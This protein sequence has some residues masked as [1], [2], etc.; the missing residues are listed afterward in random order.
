MSFF[1]FAAG[2]IGKLAI[3]LAGRSLGETIKDIRTQR[4]MER[5]VADAVDRVVEQIDGYLTGEKVSDQRK[6]VLIASLCAN[7]Q[8]LTDDPQRF[9]AGNLDGALIFKQCHPD[10]KLP[11]EI[12]E[13]DLGH[14]YTM[15][16]PQIAHFLAGSRIALAQWQA[17]GYREEF[18]RLTQIAEEIRA[19]NVKVAELPGAVTRAVA[20]KADQEAQTLLREFAQ[21][22]LNNLLLRLDLSPLRAER[23]LHGSLREHFVIPAFR[24]RREHAEAVGKETVIIE[25][26]AAAGARRLVHGGAGVGKTT[27]SLWLQSRLLESDPTRLAVLLR[28]REITD[29][30]K[31][32]LL[33]LLRER[34]GTHLRDALTD[35][36]LR[37]WHRDGRLVVILDGFDEVPEDRRDAVEQWVKGLDAAAKKTTI[38]VTS[39][40]LQ[41]GHL[42]GLKRPWQ[43]WDLL[44]FDEPRIVEFIE[45]WH[46]YLPEGELSAAER[47]VDPRALA[48]TFFNDPSLKPL[49][50]TPLMLGTLLFVHHRDKKLPS[51]RVDLYERY[52]AAMLG[53]RDSGLGIQA[54]ATKLT[55]KE[56]RHVLAHIALHFHLNSVNE[57]ND[58]TMRQLVN[59]ALAKFKFDEDGERLLPA[60][61]ERTGL[62]QGPGAW[63]FMHKTIGEFLVA[64]LIC[65]GTTRL[66]DKRR[67]DR[68]EL[69]THRHKD[70]WT[71][72]LFFWGGKTSPRELEE[73]LVD[74]LNEAAGEATLLALSLLHDQGDRLTHDAQRSLAALL[75]AKPL[76]SHGPQSFAHCV[77]PAAPESVYKHEYRSRNYELR[78]LSKVN[79]T[80]A[81]VGLFARGLLTPADLLNPQGEMRDQLTIAALWALGREATK[82][83]I[84]IRKYLGHLPPRDLALYCMCYGLFSPIRA[85]RGDLQRH[86]NAL[87][88]WLKAFPEGRAWVSLVLVGALVEGELSLRSFASNARTQFGP[89]L[90][91]WRDEPVDD[92]WLRESDTCRGWPGIRG[93]D[94]LKKARQSLEKN[95]PNAWGITAEQHA[96]LLAWCDHKM[97]RRAE[98]KAAAKTGVRGQSKNSRRLPGG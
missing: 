12:R 87:A 80:Q 42:E 79:S 44:P 8:S 50:D 17:E 73:F 92:D 22:L 13:E 18:K 94:V 90:W 75:I 91:E 89:L 40:P 95:D 61:R 69:W 20:S 15:L 37:K 51:G 11:Q 70:E 62:L 29:I 31:H 49:A 82:L 19:M 4:R 71:T 6:Q 9:F 93:V 5:M 54:R 48:R 98:L 88:E 10:G 67:L 34:V 78:G 96:D 57:V 84:E 47:K 83:T 66:P 53:L 45:R 81:F 1:T 52:I 7:L 86:R 46:R 56:K 58:E 2:A 43:Q 26:L 30:E 16:F 55:D 14:F 77:T 33:D 68:K 3:S 63:S 38:I 85:G 97:A 60:L 36:V 25:A 39:R 64:E 35:K 74:L 76:P 23:A 41:S 27:W 24:E 65:D 72:V 32:S 28:L 59:E 21:T